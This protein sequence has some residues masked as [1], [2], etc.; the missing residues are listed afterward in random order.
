MGK[1]CGSIDFPKFCDLG[2]PKTPP[3]SYFTA[4]H[5]PPPAELKQASKMLG[6]EI[7]SPLEENPTHTYGMLL[8]YKS[9][10]ESSGK[11]FVGP[12]IRIFLC[13]MGL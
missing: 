9:W 10:W 7:P 2:H 3:L 11:S 6:W 12:Y 1:T 13:E 5:L 4:Q 8:I